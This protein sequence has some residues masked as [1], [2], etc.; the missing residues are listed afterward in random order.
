MFGIPNKS[1]INERKCD[2]NA[3]LSTL[4]QFNMKNKKKFACIRITLF[5]IFTVYTKT[6][7]TQLIFFLRK[8]N[9]ILTVSYK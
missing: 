8:L 5:T 6:Y 9:K 3:C 7:G 2:T 1:D 4:F